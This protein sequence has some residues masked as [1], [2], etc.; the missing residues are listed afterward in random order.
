MRLGAIDPSAA[1]WNIGDAQN[2]MSSERLS[3]NAR[4]QVSAC[5]SMLLWVSTAPWVDRWCRRCT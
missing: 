1:M 3:W 5:A 2:P 4:I